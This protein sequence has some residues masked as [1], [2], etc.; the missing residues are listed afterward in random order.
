M[1]AIMRDKQKGFTLVE[2]MIVVA[3]IGICV[4]LL[5]NSCGPKHSDTS[6]KTTYILSNGKY[7]H[8]GRIGYNHCGVDL[9]DC[10]DGNEYSCLTNL[11]TVPNKNN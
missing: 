1:E 5:M 7:V 9:S 4:S 3:I 8:C 6:P 2:L 10:E 11:T